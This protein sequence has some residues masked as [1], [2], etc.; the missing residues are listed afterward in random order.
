MLGG[1]RSETHTGRIAAERRNCGEPQNPGKG[2]ETVRIYVSADMEGATGVVSALQTRSD[3]PAEY[4]FGC[5]MEFHDVMA[6]IE[7]AIEGGAKE[8]LVN[9]SHARMINL[10]ISGLPENVRLLSGTPKAL[11]MVEGVEGYDGAFFTAYHAMSGTPLAVLDHTV[12]GATLYDVRLNGRLVGET[13]INGAV[14]AAFG[15]PVALVTGDAAVCREASGLLGENL[16]TCSVKEAHG[17]ASA[18]CFPPSRTR[19]LLREAAREATLRIASKRAPVQKISLP[20]ELELTFKYSR[21]CDVVSYV[22][23]VERIDG[24]TVRMRDSDM[25]EMRRWI[26]VATGLAGA[27]AL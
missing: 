5:K 22:P 17:N 4:A 8:I 6:V 2:D 10:D 3:H 12:S 9:D 20:Y 24:R 1:R 26:N 13:G 23:G 14:C 16:V 21:Q 18:D 25:V 11:G 19:N 15:V 7:G 27:V